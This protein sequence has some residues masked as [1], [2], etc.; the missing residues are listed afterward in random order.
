LLNPSE[1]VREAS[2]CKQLAL[3]E[4]F[5]PR[6]FVPVWWGKNAHTM[7]IISTLEGA[8]FDRAPAVEYRRVWLETPDGDNIAVDFLVSFF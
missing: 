5:Q 7:T 4:A 3:V 6:D 1:A 8:L 2:I